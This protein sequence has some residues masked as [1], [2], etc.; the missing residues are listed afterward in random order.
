[1]NSTPAVHAIRNEAEHAAV[2]AEFRAFVDTH[3]DAGEGTAEAAY[4]DAQGAVLEAFEQ[5]HWP[6]P[7]E[8]GDA[9]DPVDLIRQ[10][11]AERGIP[12]RELAACFGSQPN[13]SAVLNRR[14]GLTLPMVRRL[15]EK[16]GIP[17]DLLIR[18]CRRRAARGRAAQP[19]A[20]KGVPLEGEPPRARMRR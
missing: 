14:R 20:R 18:E 15:H 3:L 9:W 17:A 1:M 7:A 19:Q 4:I 16:L 5:R 12:Q 8:W 10:T 11:M 6:T 2:R 13:C